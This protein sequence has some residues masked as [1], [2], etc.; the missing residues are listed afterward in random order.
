MATYYKVVR[1]HM[2]GALTSVCLNRNNPFYRV[3]SDSQITKDGMA[4]DNLKAA[5]KFRYD[6]IEIGIYLEVWS[7][8]GKKIKMPVRSFYSSTVANAQD[9]LN[10]ILYGKPFR[11][12]MRNGSVWPEY[13]VRL[14]NI[15]LTKRIV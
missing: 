2:G 9:I 10:Y 5:R 13:A 11:D 3:Y 7:C 1:R 6:Q 12:T 4:F 14:R 15:K 8:T